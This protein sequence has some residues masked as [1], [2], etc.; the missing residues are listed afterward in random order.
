MPIVDGYTSTKMIRSFEK[1][2]P[3]NTLSGRAGLDG[4]IP[5][6]AVSASL[7]EKNR[8]MYMDI[9]FDGWILRPIDFKRVN[10]ILTGLVEEGARED[11]LYQPGKWEQGGWFEKRNADVFT[12]NIKPTEQTPG[13]APE[14]CIHEKPLPDTEGPER[15]VTI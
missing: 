14:E 11:A 3:S 9:G 2:H 8:Q 4:R 1:S 10:H 15:S 13:S 6:F 7:V 12:A 5:I